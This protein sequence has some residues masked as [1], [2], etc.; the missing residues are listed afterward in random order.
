MR[1]R[2]CSMHPVMVPRYPGYLF[3]MLPAT[4][5]WLRERVRSIP[6]LMANPFLLVGGRVAVVD[7]AT[8]R[9]ACQDELICIT[10]PAPLAPVIPEMTILRSLQELQSAMHAT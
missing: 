4:D 8:V 5:G 3:A 9:E 10:D 7:Y 6:S 1:Y 2:L